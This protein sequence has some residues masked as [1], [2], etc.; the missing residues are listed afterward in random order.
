MRRL[1]CLLSCLLSVPALADPPLSPGQVLTPAPIPTPPPT[2]YSV[3]MVTP[4][5]GYRPDPQ[6]TAWPHISLY[7]AERLHTMGKKKHV[8]FVDARAEVEWQGGRVP[9]SI[10]IP[11]GEFDKAFK[12]HESRIKSAKVI[13]VYCHGGGCHLSEN[14]CKRFFDKGFRNVVNFYGGWPAWQQANLPVEDKDG[15]VTYPP[16]A[17]P[18]QTSPTAK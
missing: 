8:L 3:R 14:E 15:K 12:K 13:V 9:R 10:N 17:T 7:E 16:V 18:T 6:Y 4:E 2:P 5:A 1:L 11:L